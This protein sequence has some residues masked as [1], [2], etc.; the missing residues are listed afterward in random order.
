MQEEQQALLQQEA[1]HVPCL[2]SWVSD[3]VNGKAF[4]P[5]QAAICC[6]TPQHLHHLVQLHTFPVCILCKAI[7]PGWLRTLQLPLLMD[8]RHTRLGKSM[9]QNRLTLSAGAFLR[10]TMP[11]VRPSRL[12]TS[13]VISPRDTSLKRTLSFGDNWPIFQSSVDVTVQGHTKPP[14]LGPSCV[15]T[16]GMSPGHSTVYVALLSSE[17]LPHASLY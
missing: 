8:T 17:C 13:T 7:V 15:R 9:I 3:L 6:S 16:I 2:T 12:S 14:K 10:W 4:K 11:K 5:I 1:R